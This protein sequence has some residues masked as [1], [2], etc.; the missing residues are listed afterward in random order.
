M[1]ET[2]GRTFGEMDVMFQRGISAR[3]SAKYE[4]TSDDMFMAQEQDNRRGG[5]NVKN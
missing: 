4:L 1:F 3:K 2:K 5:E